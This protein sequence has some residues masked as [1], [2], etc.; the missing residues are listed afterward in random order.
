VNDLIVQLID[1]HVGQL[2]V[3]CALYADDIALL[4][5]SASCYG[6]QKLVD[7]CTCYGAIW[8]ITFNPLKSELITLGGYNRSSCAISLDGNPIPWVTKV[9]YLGVRLL[10]LILVLLTCQRCVGDFMVSL[11]IIMPVLGRQSNEIS[12][13]YL[14]KTYCLPTLM[15]GCEKRTLTDSSLHKRNSAWNNSFRRIFSCCLRERELVSSAFLSFYLLLEQRK[16]ISWM[17]IRRTNNIVLQTP[18]F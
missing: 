11:I 18:N 7:I 9:K 10:G 5:A 2:F 4:S 16:L 12:A 3:G 15:Y 6:L 14:T 17:K 1:K 13:V 8:G